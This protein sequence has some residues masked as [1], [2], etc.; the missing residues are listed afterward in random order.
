[1]PGVLKNDCG[2]DGEDLVGFSWEYRIF[3]SRKPIVERIKILLGLGYFMGY[4]M[5]I[6]PPVI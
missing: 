2:S 5:M 1:V 6:Y 4:F 3:H